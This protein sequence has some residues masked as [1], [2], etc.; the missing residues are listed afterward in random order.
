MK[1]LI[2]YD[3]SYKQQYFKNTFLDLWN[4]HLCMEE[5]AAAAAVEEVVEE[6]VEEEDVIVADISDHLLNSRKII[7]KQEDKENKNYHDMRI[8]NLHSR[9]I[10]TSPTIYRTPNYDITQAI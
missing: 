4:H 5:E 6:G 3:E 8:K 1:K 10:L 9:N 7:G 2:I